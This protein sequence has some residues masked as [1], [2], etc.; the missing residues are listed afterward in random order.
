MQKIIKSKQK[1]VSKE[2][3]TLFRANLRKDKAL[4]ME[5]A[6]MEKIKEGKVKMKPKLY[7]ILGTMFSI[8][9]LA[10]IS[11]SCAFLINII[12]FVL[13]RH[14][15]MGQWRLNVIFDSFPIWI[16][17]VAITGIVFGIWLLKK[18]DFSYKKNF[19]GIAVGFILSILIAGY[20]ID[21]MG[22]NDVLSQK[23][24]MRRFYQNIEGQSMPT[25]GFYKQE[26]QSESCNGKCGLKNHSRN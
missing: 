15:P 18:Y 14:G 12:L 26:R 23:G 2:Q 13:K 10:G 8:A 25:P 19:A 1:I 7:F 17:V 16:P 4:N 20:M 22:I 21:K 24:T 3:K 6:I 11:V 5:K 9:G